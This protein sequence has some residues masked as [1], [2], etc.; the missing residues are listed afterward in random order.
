MPAGVE[1]VDS[2]RGVGACLPHE[3]G[4]PTPQKAML[5]VPA[6]LA[7]LLGRFR[8]CFTAPTFVTFCGLV[9]GLLAC[10]GRRTVCGMLVAARL[11]RTW[12]HDRVH[13]FFSAARWSTEQLSA[14]AARLVAAW[15]VADGQP[16]TV[17]ID[18]TLF[19]RR[20]PKVHA[21]G[22]FHDGSAA[23]SHKVGY[24]N[25][26][27]IAAIV[28][29]LPFTTR[30]VALPVAAALVGKKPSQS[31][32][33]QRKQQKHGTQTG[34]RLALAR[35]LVEHLAAALP[36]RRI[37]VVADAAYAGKV[38][39]GLPGQITWTTRM[40]AKAGLYQPAPPPTGKRG[41][42]AQCGAHL[43]KPEQ[44]A[45][46]LTFTPT[47]VYRYGQ[48]ATLGLAALRC[49]WHGVFG[50]QEVQVVFVRNQTT[51]TT[52][53]DIALVSTDLSATAAQLVERYATRWSV[54]VA[55]EDAKQTTGV[56]QARNRTPTAVQRTVPFGLIANTLAICWYATAGHHPDDP[57]TIRRLAPWYRSKTHPSVSDM[58]AKLRRVIIA[59]QF[60]GPNPQAPTPEEINTLRLA[61][62]QSTP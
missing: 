7:D 61:W 45:N 47:T 28:V 55:I 8:G 9:C 49:L 11:S 4:T 10:T 52:G 44:L 50:T 22:W 24:G 33:Q 23:G 34:T 5:A 1:R 43:P 40:R 25:N 12:S 42:P 36:D 14:V 27:V 56:G 58:L 15:L 54:E 31:R 20:G 17:A 41:R 18:D 57:N 6:S 21:A 32:S 46:T 19:H 51:T 59:A 53:Y 13:R 35:G 37:E 2:K 3:S 60:P 38:L 30:P 26:W 29:W 39:R 16:V 62:S 48:K